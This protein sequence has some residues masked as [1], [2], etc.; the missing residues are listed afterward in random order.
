[1]ARHS[2]YIRG[3]GREPEIETVTNCHTTIVTPIGELTLVRNRGGLAGVYFPSHWHLPPSAKFGAR[4]DD[5]FDDVA[6]QMAEYLRGER[7]TF[8]FPI[9]I[10]GDDFERAVWQLIGEVPYGATATYG[11][12]ARALGSEV[13]PR[14]VGGAVGRNPL[15]LIVPCHRIVGAGGKLTGYAG[16]L[17]RKRALLDLEASVTGSRGTLF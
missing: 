10:D 17:D 5:G 8:D 13:S 7:R 4:V 14:V 1:V 6:A 16:G 11:E 15:S 12:L 9:S 3:R 2:D